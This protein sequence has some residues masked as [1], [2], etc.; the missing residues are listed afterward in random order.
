MNQE[1]A[2]TAPRAWPAWLLAL[3]MA[4]AVLVFLHYFRSLGRALPALPELFT[5][6]GPGPGIAV[7]LGVWWGSAWILLCSA[8]LVGLV[9]AWG[10]RLRR[11]LGLQAGDPWMGLALAYGLGILGFDL[12]WLGAGLAH[13]WWRP[14]MGALLALGFAVALGDALRYWRAGDFSWRLP[15]E[16]RWLTATALLYLLL[17]LGLGL[18]PETFYDSMVYHLAIPSDWLM[19]HGILDCPTNFFSNYP[20]GAELY[21][22]NGL[23]LQGTEAAKCLHAAAFFF[24]A[25]A[26]GG[27]ARETAGSGAGW[28]AFGMVLTL[29][30]MAL[31]A[32]TTQV[33]GVLAFFIVLLLYALWKAFGPAPAGGAWALAAG[34]LAGGALSVKYTAAVALGAG[35]LSLGRGIFRP[36]AMRAWAAL[37]GGAVLLLG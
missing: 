1:P 31:N 19:R 8:V 27:W 14:L 16:H 18:A 2:V 17:V 28:L 25:L 35:L 24:C 23:F 26:A 11:W 30:L 3:P 12:L 29:P 22:L 33:E 6:A 4:W 32:S 21:F 15:R 10:I 7:R 37:A 9:L 13:L 5:A 34:L 36:G 20:Y